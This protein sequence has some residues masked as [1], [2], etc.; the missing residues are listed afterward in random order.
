MAGNAKSGLKRMMD[1]HPRKE[2]FRRDLLSTVRG[3]TTLKAMAQKYGVSLNTVLNYRNTIKDE[4]KLAEYSRDVERREE[5]RKFL[6][7]LFLSSRRL[8]ESVEKGNPLTVEGVP[9]MDRDGSAIRMV[10]HKAWA[11]SL[12]AAAGIARLGAEIHGDIGP[13]AAA[14]E[15]AKGG[16]MGVQLCLVIPGPD[17]P[18][19][20]LVEGEVMDVEA[21]DVSYEEIGEAND[22]GNG[23]GDDHNL[24]LPGM[25]DVGGGDPGAGLADG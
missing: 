6:D 2:E 20:L 23:N 7:D 24:F 18:D 16:G 15:L 8:L 17:E 3:E 11:S 4:L 10:D 21:G 19:P 5:S 1:S 25:D 9:L 13:K 12:G 14:Q 22:Y